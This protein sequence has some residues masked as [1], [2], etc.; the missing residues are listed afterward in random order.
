VTKHH[1]DEASETEDDK[2]SE[3]EGDKASETEGDNTGNFLVFLAGRE[4][5][6]EEGENSR[7]RTSRIY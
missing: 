5:E 1:G 4:K 2:A 3:T 6:K 7:A